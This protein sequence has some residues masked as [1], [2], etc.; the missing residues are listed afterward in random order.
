MWLC[1][2]RAD[3][4]AGP[5]AYCTMV[6]PIAINSRTI[7]PLFYLNTS[8]INCHKMQQPKTTTENFCCR[9]CGSEIPEGALL[10]GGHQ[11]SAGLPSSG[12]LTGSHG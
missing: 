6:V 12:G 1:P 8:G 4:L 10:H 3:G 5:L 9:M 2:G 11:T 7:I